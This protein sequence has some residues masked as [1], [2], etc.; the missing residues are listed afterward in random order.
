[1]VLVL[2]KKEWYLSYN[3][4]SYARVDIIIFEISAKLSTLEFHTLSREDRTRASRVAS[5]VW[6]R[7]DEAEFEVFLSIFR[8]RWKVKI[9]ASIMSSRSGA[10]IRRSDSC[11]CT[12]FGSEAENETRI[13]LIIYRVS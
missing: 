7:N 5:W 6:F 3:Q 2:M 8:K 13:E 10:R 4:F 9:E 11:S 1:M 12:P